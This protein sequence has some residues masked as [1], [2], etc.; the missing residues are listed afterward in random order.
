MIFMK[1]MHKNT[2]KLLLAISCWSSLSAFACNLPTS[3]YKNVICTS[4]QGV[5]LA[6]RDNKEPVALLDNKGN[7][8]A[9]L[10]S[11]QD[12]LATHMAHGLLPVRQGQYIGYINSKG[13]VIIPIKYDSLGAPDFARKANN[14]RII[15]KYNGAFG[16]IDT[17]GKVIVDFDKS[18]EHISD[19]SKNQALVSQNK[20]QYTISQ[21]G[22]IIND[23]QSLLNYQNNVGHPS[24]N[25]NSDNV[26]NDDAIATNTINPNHPNSADNTNDSNQNKQSLLAQDTPN[27]SFFPNQ[28]DDKWGFVDE[29][30]IP[31][32][33]HVFDEVRPF[34][35]GLAGVRVD[36]HWGFIDKAGKLVIPFRFHQD[37]IKHDNQ[38]DNDTNQSFV[39]IND[40]AWV[41]NFN[42][43]IRLCINI[44][45]KNVICD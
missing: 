20:G 13:K 29:H 31:M 9:D 30:G 23:K 1:K 27:K 2:I 3:Y 24:D 34:S 43:D 41:S 14:H 22:N 15:V 18:I 5:F 10:F 45:G 16:V 25:P 37:R 21:H 44:Y 28:Q 7:K 11:Y 36:S 4:E 17:K 33:R 32:I 12:A 6:M 19:F 42:D 26:N 39:F 38:S 40:K 8:T 35:Q